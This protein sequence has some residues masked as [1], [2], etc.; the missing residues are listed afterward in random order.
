MPTIEEHNE[1][2]K[3]A[4]AAGD[5][6]AAFRIK[7]LVEKQQQQQQQQQ[8]LAVGTDIAPRPESTL[9]SRTGDKGRDT[10]NI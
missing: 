5:T 7:Q 8:Q 6:L 4:L 2:Y 1:A 10:G 3:K 9:L